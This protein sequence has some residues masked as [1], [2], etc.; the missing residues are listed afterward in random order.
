MKKLI[1]ILL[2]V[3]MIVSFCGAAM[4]ESADDDS[5]TPNDVLQ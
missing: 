2:T 5:F 4:A 3:I 1:S